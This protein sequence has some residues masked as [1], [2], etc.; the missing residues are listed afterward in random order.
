MSEKKQFSGHPA[1][2]ISP[3]KVVPLVETP[4]INLSDFQ[5]APGKHYYVV[6]RHQ[7]E[8]M[9]LLK[10]KEEFM[11]MHADAVTCVLVLHSKTGS[12]EPRLVL[13]Y[14]F[15]YPTGQY[16]L[17]PPAGLM[18]KTDPDLFST[19]RREILEETGLYLQEGDELTVL[20]PLVFSSPGMT[21]E[22]NALV[23]CNAYV[24]S[25]EVLSQDGAEE[26]ECFN[27]FCLLT[28]EEARRILASGRDEHGV[29]YSIYTQLALLYFGYVL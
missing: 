26:T 28:K 8:D 21:D 27:G 23:L 29:F 19:A 22:S 5:F 7:K 18:D 4:Y 10:S 11:A 25:L 14:E 15:R 24:D 6:S 9:P 17:S 16:L 1:P 13:S 2:E 12:F 3:E 20:N